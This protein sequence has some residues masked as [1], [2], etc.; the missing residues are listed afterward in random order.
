[1]PRHPRGL[2]LPRKGGLGAERCYC[3][4]DDLPYVHTLAEHYAAR[5]QDRNR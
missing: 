4:R 1:M 5:P 3:Q 2:P